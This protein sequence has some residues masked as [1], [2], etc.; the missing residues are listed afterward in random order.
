MPVSNVKSLFLTFLTVTLFLTAAANESEVDSVLAA[1]NGEPV[2]LGEIL[3]AVRHR[4]FQLKSAYSGKVLEEEIL[5]ARHRAVE[6]IIDSKLIAADF[7]AKKLVLS[8]QDI[9]N[10]LDRWGKHIGCPTRKDLEEKIRQSGTTIEKLR[11]RVVQRMK[12]QIMRRRAFAVAGSPTPADLYERFKK[13]EKFL[14]FPGSAELALIKIPLNDTKNADDIS[15]SLKKNPLLWN[16]YAKQFAVTP[17]TDG[18]IGSVDLDKL[19]PEFAKAM[20]TIAPGQIYSNIKTADGIYFI[21][22][23]KYTPPRKAV[24]KEHSETIRKKMEEEIYKKSSAAY[25]A[26]LRSKAVIEYFFPVPKG[27]SKK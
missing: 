11:E 8:A 6:E 14:T 27:A 3:P 23:L 7:D 20:K 17:G 4:E 21:K 2:T 24:F 25:A 22:V 12:V 15:A 10:E 16:Q 13:E 9:E 19:R 1:V 26:R 18:N 5:K